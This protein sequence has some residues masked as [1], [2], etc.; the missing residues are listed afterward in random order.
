MVVSIVGELLKK[1]DGRAQHHLLHLW[2]R[3][4]NQPSAMRTFSIR[5]AM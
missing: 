1:F 3:E 4:W 5:R 2:T